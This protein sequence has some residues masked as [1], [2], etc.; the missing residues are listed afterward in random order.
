MKVILISVLKEIGE[1]L[2]L[3]AARWL[4]EQ[5]KV[6]K[7]NSE[8]KKAIKAQINAKTKQE[9]IDAIRRLRKHVNEL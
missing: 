4:A 3:K 7:E 9:K 6:M 8:L 1:W 2:F 5:F